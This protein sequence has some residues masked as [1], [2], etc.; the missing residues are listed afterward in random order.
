VLLPGDSPFGLEPHSGPELGW[1]HG[2]RQPAQADSQIVR[3][4]EATMHHHA[5]R[6][7]DGPKVVGCRFYQL[8]MADW[9][10]SSIASL[11][12]AEGLRLGLSARAKFVKNIL[13][14]ALRQ[15]RVEGREIGFGPAP[16][17]IRVCPRPDS[18]PVEFVLLVSD[19]RSAGWCGGRFQ[20]R[21]GSRLSHVCR[22]RIS[23]S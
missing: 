13:P 9:V 16:V 10:E 11:S 7:Q 18:W 23:F 17:L 4:T 21:R 5:R 6:F 22:A 20:N 3:A 1:Q 15:M 14:G 12:L 19:H 8:P 2:P